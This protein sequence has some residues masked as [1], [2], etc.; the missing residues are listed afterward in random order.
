MQSNKIHLS[1]LPNLKEE[2]VPPK[3]DRTS[4]KGIVLLPLFQGYPGLD[5]VGDWSAQSACWAH[6]SWLLYTDA[7]DYGVEVKFYIE[8]KAR[9]SALPVLEQNFVEP[10]DI[11][12]HDE[13]K[14]LEGALLANDGRGYVTRGIKKCASYLDSRFADYDWILDV[15]TDIFIMSPNRQKLP[16]FH[17]FFEKCVADAIGVSWFTNTRDHPQCLTPL[18]LGWCGDELA[19]WKSRFEALVGREM[20]EMYFDSERWIPACNGGIVAVPAKYFLHHRRRDLEFIVQASRD[21]LDQEAAL[22]L[23]QAM[24]NPV[25]SVYEGIKYSN[26]YSDSDVGEVRHFADA[27]DEASP[28][29]LHYAA[30]SIHRYWYQG[31]GVFND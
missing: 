18:D 17:N 6:R 16:F 9:A 20:L 19:A 31:I 5:V 15:D 8:E 25:F 12:W 30:S 22:S 29:L 21:L 28:F 14:R 1:K 23:Y 13:G 26:L 2:Q 27:Y 4:S 11:I 3:P 10:A 7:I 24:G